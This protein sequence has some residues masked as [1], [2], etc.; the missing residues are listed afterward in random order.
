MIELIMKKKINK[1]FYFCYSFI[2]FLKIC[3]LKT[4]ILEYQLLIFIFDILNFKNLQKKYF[5]F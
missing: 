2:L 5:F 4:R 1:I 3:N